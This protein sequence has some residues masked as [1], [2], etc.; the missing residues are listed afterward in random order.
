MKSCKV[1]VKQE[2]MVHLS[3]EGMQIQLFSLTTNH[4]FENR[5]YI[6]GIKCHTI[7]ENEQICLKRSI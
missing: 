3:T 7:W 1:E 5:G 4:N 6:M 2:E